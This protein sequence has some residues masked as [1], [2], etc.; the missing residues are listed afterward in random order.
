MPK[1]DSKPKTK[2]PPKKKKKT[3]KQMLLEMDLDKVEDQ[4]NINSNNFLS[5]N[6]IFKIIL[7]GNME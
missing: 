6:S 7:D 4:F 1:K 2:L 3:S 5:F